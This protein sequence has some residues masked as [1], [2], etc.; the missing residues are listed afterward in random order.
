MK[1]VVFWFVKATLTV[2]LYRSGDMKAFCFAALVGCFALVGQFSHAEE[3]PL[4]G[5]YIHDSGELT[6]T[7][8]FKKEKKLV[9]KVE[10]G[11]MGCT[12]EC[13]YTITKEGVYECVLEKFSKQGDFP[14]EKEKGYTFNFKV[15]A[16]KA[17][18]VLS[19]FKG[20]ASDEEA[21][22]AIEGKYTLKTD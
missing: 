10:A 8:T 18:F 2:S 7:M 5:S 6:L 15:K 12:L 20:E 11:E 9:I 17:A 13:K 3:K 16:E 21:K 19:D 4:M 22:G 1:P 14:V